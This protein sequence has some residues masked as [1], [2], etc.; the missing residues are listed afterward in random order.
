MGFPEKR[1]SLVKYLIRQGI[2]KTPRIIKA[3]ETVPRENFV[4][5]KY[6]DQ[7]YSD[8]P[9]PIGFNQTISAPHMVSLMSELLEPK[10]TDKVL[11]VGAGSGYQAAILSRLVKKIYTV[12]LEPGLVKFAAQNIKKTGYKN[13][14]IMEGDGSK[15]YPKAAPY[16]KVIVTC[17]C[18]KIPGALVEQLKEDGILL[19]PVGGGW[20]QDLILGRKKKGKLEI[21]RYGSCVFVPLRH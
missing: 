19:A 13:V 17:A 4:L 11:E 20:A 2:L 12:E 3:F 21:K 7:A 1:K 10:K 15:G 18:P 14:Q 9:M 16:D 8:Q 5:E 6:R